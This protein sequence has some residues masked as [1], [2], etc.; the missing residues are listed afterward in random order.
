MKEPTMIFLFTKRSKQKDGFRMDRKGS[1]SEDEKG[2]ARIAYLFDLAW[3][4]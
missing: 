4:M 2:I 1:V 3:R